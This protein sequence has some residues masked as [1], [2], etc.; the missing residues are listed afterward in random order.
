LPENNCK[1]ALRIRLQKQQQA[2]NQTSLQFLFLFWNAAYFIHHLITF[3]PALK[4]SGC[5]T[6]TAAC[7]LYVPIDYC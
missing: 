3:I 2:F 7:F 1:A 6:V 4:A 5:Y